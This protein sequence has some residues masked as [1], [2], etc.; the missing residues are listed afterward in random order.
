MLIETSLLAVDNLLITLCSVMEEY[1]RYLA[2]EEVPLTRTIFKENGESQHFLPV[3]FVPL[4][5]ASGSL[6]PPR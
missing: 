6:D 4:D 5:A 1:E 2:M 3:V